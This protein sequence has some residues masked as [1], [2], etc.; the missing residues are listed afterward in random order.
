[1]MGYVN[2]E[3]YVR[4]YV[5]GSHE[6]PEHVLVVERVLG[7]PLPRGAVVHHVDGNRARNVGSNLVVCPDAAYHNLIH[8]RAEALRVTGNANSRKCMY[9]G[10]YDAPANLT[11]RG[12]ARVRAMHPACHSAYQRAWR[13]GRA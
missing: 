6:R 3:G 5:P 10:S 8:M 9:C 12:K 1:M 2:S 13:R 7:K 11:I 4:C